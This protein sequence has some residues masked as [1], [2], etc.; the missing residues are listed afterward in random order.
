MKQ[1]HF[2]LQSAALEKSYYI[3]DSN[4][5]RALEAAK[6]E[7]DLDHKALGVV[8]MSCCVV[9]QEQTEI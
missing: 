6:I 3:Q 7:F 2:Y 9:L 1:W 8:P 4:L 5:N